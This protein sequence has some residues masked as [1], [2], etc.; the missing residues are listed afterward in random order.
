MNVF[1]N[2][3][4]ILLIL[5]A[6]VIGLGLILLA[7]LVI[8][9]GFSLFGLHYVSGDTQ[10]VGDYINLGQATESSPSYAEQWGRT[11]TVSINTL[12]WDIELCPVT[13]ANDNYYLPYSITALWS[14]EYNGFVVGEV[15][16]PEFT[17]GEFMEN[18]DGTLTLYYEVREPDGGWISKVNTELLILFNASDFEGKDIVINTRSGTVKIGDRLRYETD[19]N[20]QQTKVSTS[21]TSGDIDITNLSGNITICDVNVGGD[22][23]IDKDSGDFVSQV[24]LNNNVFID[25]DKGFG[26]VTLQDVGTRVGYT[27]LIFREINNSNI[28]FGQV[29]GDL[30]FDGTGG[31]IRG[32]SVDGLLSVRGGNCDVILEEVAGMIDWTSTDGSLE[33]GTASGEV[34][35]RCTGSGHIN[36]DVALGNLNIETN[37]GAIALPE[38]RG[39]VTLDTNNGNIDVTGTQV[40]AVYTITSRGGRTTLNNIYGTV[41]FTAKENGNASIDLHYVELRGENVINTQTGNITVTVGSGMPFYLNNWS[42]NNSVDIEVSGCHSEN[43]KMENTEYA[44]GTAVSAGSQSDSLTLISISGQ[45]SLTHAIQ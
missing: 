14:R 31:L 6:I 24:D 13:E 11:S 42:T 9:P 29:R 33:L 25:I 10:K 34:T 4:K 22:V 7:G 19:E 37:N 40:S 35:A 12:S 30:S 38:T 2:I 41:N 39:N 8:F 44:G 32:E 43:S 23:N 16:E 3:L 26:T 17:G 18:G 5:V 21:F 15:A 28:T 45:I 20:D 36:I 1:V 27:G